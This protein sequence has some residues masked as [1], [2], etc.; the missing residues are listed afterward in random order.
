MQ[1]L[2]PLETRAYGW[3]VPPRR[4]LREVMKRLEDGLDRGG[5]HEYGVSYFS[6]DLP[7]VDI[8]AAPENTFNLEVQR[9]WMSYVILL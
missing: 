3:E 2:R 1:V 5:L 8:R 6:Y 7:P 4:M 9:K